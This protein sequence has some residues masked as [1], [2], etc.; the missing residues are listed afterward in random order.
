MRSTEIQE[1]RETV[2]CGAG[3]NKH[4]ESMYVGDI[5]AKDKDNNIAQ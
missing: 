1:E 2:C 5:V 3:V 4:R